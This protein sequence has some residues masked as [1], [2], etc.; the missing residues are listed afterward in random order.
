MKSKEHKGY[1]PKEIDVSQGNGVSP[2]VFVEQI[3]LRH[4]LSFL[5][6]L[7][8]GFD[9]LGLGKPLVQLPN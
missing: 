7:R 6:R 4:G 5:L 2:E 3:V 9:G 8:E 1:E